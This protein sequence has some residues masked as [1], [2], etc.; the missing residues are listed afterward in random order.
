MNSITNAQ[1]KKNNEGLDE[2]SSKP[3]R[4]L[5]SDPNRAMQEMML[6]IDRMR[7][8]MILE[9]AAL[10]EADTRKFMDLQDEKLDVA[11]D[12]LDGMSQL[13]AR[14]DELKNADPALQDRLEAMRADFSEIAQENH[15]ALERM[16][17]GM[18]R[19]GDRIM[20]TAREASRREREIIYGGNGQM[21]SGFKTTM[22]I[23]ES[24]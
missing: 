11:R 19:L 22:G 10:K 14:K 21:Q 4:R 13:L 3:K 20:E 12:Y 9:T 6:T 24:A 15:A 5:P 8:S 1:D 23:N 7:S 18:K 2:A 16:K 17:N